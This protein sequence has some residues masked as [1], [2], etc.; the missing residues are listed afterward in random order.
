M[1]TASISAVLSINSKESKYKFTPCSLRN[2]SCLFSLEQAAITL[3]L[4]KYRCT[5][6]KWTL[7]ILPKPTIPKLTID[8]RVFS[9]L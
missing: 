5:F 4:V 6:D 8:L 2:S 9:C 7:P 3:A 1:I